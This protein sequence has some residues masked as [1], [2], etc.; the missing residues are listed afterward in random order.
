[1]RSYICRFFNSGFSLIPAKTILQANANSNMLL[2]SLILK[3]FNGYKYVININ[4]EFMS[5]YHFTNAVEIMLGSKCI[6][7][8]VE[9]TACDLNSNTCSSSS[10]YNERVE[11]VPR[12]PE[13]SV[14]TW[15]TYRYHIAFVIQI[16]SAFSSW[17]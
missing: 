6:P 17:N 9:I 2:N 3:S 11:F 5:M 14:N 1:M 12:T 13:I 16:T 7:R 8:P 4:S 15:F 10:L